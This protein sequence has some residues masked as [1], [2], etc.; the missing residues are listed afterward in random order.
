[1]LAGGGV[2]R[3]FLS[4]FLNVVE[5]VRRNSATDQIGKDDVRI[6]SRSNFES[7][8]EELKADSEGNEQN[9]LIRGIYVLRRFCIEKKTNVFLVPEQM[10]QQHDNIRAVIYRLLDYRIIHSAGSALT[11]KSAPGTFQAYA[12]DIGCYAHMRK[13]H[14]RFVELDLFATNAKEKMRSAP[15][16]A[17]EDFRT[18][19]DAAP[20]DFESALL[21]EERNSSSDSTL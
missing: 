2:P 5:E 6:L 3:D 13:L 1:M 17:A 20:D 8:I 19:W 21:A 16:L 14:D 10:M 4:L 18:L 7:R 12:I 11:H 15:I 9:V